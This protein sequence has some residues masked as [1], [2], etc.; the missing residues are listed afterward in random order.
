[1][2]L[3]QLFYMRW[4]LEMNKVYIGKIVNTHGIKGEVRILSK[5][6]YKEEV[7]RIGNELIIDDK[8]YV[9]KSYRKHKSF[10]MVTLN[11]YT[12]INEVLFLVGKEVYFDKD[13]LVLKSNE[14]LDEDLVKF[15]AI[16]PDER[17]GKIT[18][19]FDSGA[20]NKVLRVMLDREYLIPYNEEFV[21]IDKVNHRVIIK[22]IDGM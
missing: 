22:V 8:S 5:F 21:E 19:V 2:L 4:V 6:P 13:K 14:L 18:E 17:V 16:T 9:I 15:D 11:D 3:L 10:D 1:M 20:G 7:F 12:D